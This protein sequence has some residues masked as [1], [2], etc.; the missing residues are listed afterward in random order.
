MNTGKDWKI[1]DVCVGGVWLVENYRSQF[2]SVIGNSGLT[3]LIA[4]LKDR[5]QKLE[6]N[7]GK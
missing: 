7:K 2:A 3:G 5:V 6:A 1:F 4:Q